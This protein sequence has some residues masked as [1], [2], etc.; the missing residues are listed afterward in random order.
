MISFHSI[1]VPMPDFLDTIRIQHWIAN[2]IRQH[3]KQVGDIVFVFCSDDK[4]LNINKEHL[5][6]DYYTDII[7]FNLSDQPAVIRAEIY[8]SLDRVGENAF[9]F[10]QTFEDEL[11]RVLIHGILHLVGYQDNTEEERLIMRVKEDEC[12]SLLR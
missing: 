8:I 9:M 4:L 10:G 6:H 7:T 2:V 3:Q 12:L 11:H 5:A 1:D